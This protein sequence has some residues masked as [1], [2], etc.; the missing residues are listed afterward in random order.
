[1]LKVY[2]DSVG[3]LNIHL[4][5]N[6]PLAMSI[7]KQVAQ[8]RTFIWQHGEKPFICLDHKQCKV[9]CPIQHRWYAGRVQH[10]VPIFSIETGNSSYAKSSNE[11]MPAIAEEAAEESQTALPCAY[12]QGAV[13]STVKS[14][15]RGQGSVYVP[16]TH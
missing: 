16:H 1:M 15:T 10:H 6:C 2:A 5:E 14:A 4:L 13:Q 11:Q 3:E 8:G 12:D 9:T 7:G